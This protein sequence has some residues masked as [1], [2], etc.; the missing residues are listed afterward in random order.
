MRLA[1]EQQQE[2]IRLL[3]SGQ[4]IA[5]IKACRSATGAGLKEAKEQVESIERTLPGN[6]VRND[7]GVQVK[8]GCLGAL[9]LPAAIF[10]VAALIVAKVV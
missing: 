4:K 3:K 1:A 6:T 10:L 8:G 5:A 9:L 2:I 7:A